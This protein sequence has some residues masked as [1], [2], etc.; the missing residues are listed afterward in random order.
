M[1]QALEA[2]DRAVEIQPQPNG[3]LKIAGNLEVVSGT[4]RTVLGQIIEF[5]IRAQI[6]GNHQHPC[7]R[8]LLD[9][10]PLP[11]PRQKRRPPS[12]GHFGRP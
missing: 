11:D 12:R 3:P 1:H 10:V 2:R 7:T 8:R 9:V 4:G 6:F 5:A